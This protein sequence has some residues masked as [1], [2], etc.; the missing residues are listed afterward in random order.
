M[1]EIAKAL[2]ETATNLCVRVVTSLL[3]VLQSSWLYIEVTKENIPGGRNHRLTAQIH[4]VRPLSG[5]MSVRV[6]C[7]VT[8]VVPFRLIVTFRKTG[9]EDLQREEARCRLEFDV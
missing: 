2:V 8:S 3:P 5:N 6:H 4:E 9:T 7:S 1:R